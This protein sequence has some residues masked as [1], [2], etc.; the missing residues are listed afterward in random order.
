M[1]A[2]PGAMPADESG[3]AFEVKWDGVRAITACAGGELGMRSRNGKDITL[4]YP[5]LS[6]LAGI[7]G[8][9]TI[10][11]GEVVALD[12][13]GR[14][15]FEL[16]Q[17]RMHRSDTGEIARLAQSAPVR[18]QVFDLLY[19]DGE[20]LLPL[21]YSER[22]SR[23]E[24][25]GLDGEAWSTPASRAGEG[26]ALLAAT[27]QLGLEGVIAK[28][29]ASTYRPGSRSPDWLKI[30]NLKRQELVIGGWVP[31]K[32]RQNELGALLVGHYESARSN[33]GELR[34]AGRVGTGFTAATRADLLALMR[35][36]ERDDSPFAGSAPSP[37][38]RYVE[39]ELVCEVEF[40]E[41]TREGMLRHP[42]F[43]GLRDD[44]P[45]NGVVWDLPERPSGR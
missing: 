15:S 33:P 34:F 4:R 17:G 21:P 2:R 19:E 38:A 37:E 24:A 35:P 42:S 10:L 45:A 11:D 22:R 40:T 9:G 36:I 32:G 8:A 16:L 29:L 26:S 30:K 18:L 14:P 27:A 25:L 13:A 1:L 7:L 39:P 6:P 31:Q 28:R 12:D 20:S 23:L 3:W 44:K 5:E 43:K 41:R